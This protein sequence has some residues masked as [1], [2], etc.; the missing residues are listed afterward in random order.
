MRR[1][2]P[3]A[4]G[5]AALLLLSRP[6]SAQEAGE[7]P[8]E[9]PAAKTAPP[10]DF[11]RDGLYLG[12]NFT[13]ALPYFEDHLENTIVATAVNN[14][15]LTCTTCAFLA[16]VDPSV[17]FNVRAGYRFLRHF[18]IEGQFEWLDEFDVQITETTTGGQGGT[19]IS[20]VD[21]FTATLDL[22]LYPFTG[23]LQPFVDLGFGYI[24][25]DSRDNGLIGKNFI[26]YVPQVNVN[27]H[28]LVARF[29][30]GVD[31]YINETWGMNLTAAYVAPGANLRHFNYTS[32]NAGFFYRF[33][34]P[35][36]D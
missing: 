28:E 31:F 24:E 19:D 1:G 7:E 26:L 6:A 18:A 29:G 16:D 8:S 36:R 25:L 9:A 15:G 22:K 32:L 10:E 14:P 30:G 35:E 17:G 4:A 13:Y 12:M 20:T 5:H 11:A 2:I 33:G 21:G 3:T 23:R 27:D 34:A